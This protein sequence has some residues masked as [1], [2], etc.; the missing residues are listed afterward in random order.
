MGHSFGAALATIGSV[1]YAALHP[2]MRV[3]CCGF[4]CPKVGGM[5][6]RQL[7]HS[8]PNLKVCVVVFVLLFIVHCRVAVIDNV[9]IV[10]L[11]CISFSCLY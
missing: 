1:R 8:F 5:D 2:M 6:F 9:T 7:V 11:F 4:G 10:P 3:S